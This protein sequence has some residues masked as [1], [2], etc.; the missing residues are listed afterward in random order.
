MTGI[1]QAALTAQEVAAHIVRRAE[2]EAKKV[3][4]GERLEVIDPSELS[5]SS[6]MSTLLRCT[7]L[8]LAHIVRHHSSYDGTHYFEKIR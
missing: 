6:W 4:I 3:S 8:N 5:C 2:G 7:T 1:D